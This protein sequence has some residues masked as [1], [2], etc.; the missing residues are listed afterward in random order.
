VHLWNRIL[1]TETTGVVSSFYII[2]YK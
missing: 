1:R 2:Q